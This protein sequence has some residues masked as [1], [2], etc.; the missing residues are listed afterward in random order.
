[1]QQMILG[2]EAQCSEDA[3][4]IHVGKR[5]LDVGQR[6]SLVTLLYRLPH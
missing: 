5:F 3:G 1:M 2:K 6:E 4:A